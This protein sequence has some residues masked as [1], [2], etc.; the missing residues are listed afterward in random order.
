MGLPVHRPVKMGARFSTNALAAVNPSDAKSAEG[1][2]GYARLPH[3]WAATLPAAWWKGPPEWLGAD[4]FRRD[5]THAEKVV[6][7]L[8]GVARRLAIVGCNLDP[9]S[10]LRCPCVGSSP[11]VCNRDRM[12]RAGSR[13]L[14]LRCQALS[15]APRQVEQLGI[16]TLL[17]EEH[18]NFY[19]SN[20]F[21]PTAIASRHTF[22]AA[23]RKARRVL[24]GMK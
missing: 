6:L 15:A 24:A 7:P 20:I 2:F 19:D 21:Y 10:V 17:K 14:L 3:I 23:A 11:S 18:E 5:G 13:K 12:H 9:R 1:G 16:V 4:V 8:A 22:I